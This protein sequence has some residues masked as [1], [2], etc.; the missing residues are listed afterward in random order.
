VID[1]VERYLVGVK[2]LEANRARQG[3]FAPFVAYLLDVCVLC[4]LFFVRFFFQPLLV[5]T[6][7]ASFLPQICAI[8]KRSLGLF[9]T[10]YLPPLHK[11]TIK[12]TVLFF[13]FFLSFLSFCFRKDQELVTAEAT[14]LLDVLRKKAA[15]PVEVDKMEWKLV[16]FFFNA[17]LVFFSFAQRRFLLEALDR[18]STVWTPVL[19]EKNVV[20]RFLK[21][22]L[23]AQHGELFT[24][25]TVVARQEAQSEIAAVLSR[26][27]KRSLVVAPAKVFDVLFC[28]FSVLTQKKKNR[29]GDCFVSRMSSF[30]QANWNSIAGCHWKAG[31]TVRVRKRCSFFLSY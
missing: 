22:M 10:R 24:G 18:L 19:F 7:V 15:D 29:K 13:F 14:V 11:A 6:Q 1:V 27:L 9:L 5:K 16:F 21:L 2:K 12:V 25:D 8:G 17:H 3:E 4:F 30:G 26:W 28:L 31:P 23:E 20:H